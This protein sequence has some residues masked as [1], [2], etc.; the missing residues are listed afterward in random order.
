MSLFEKREDGA[1]TAAYLERHGETI[2]DL[3]TEFVDELMQKRPE[4]VRSYLDDRL[5]KNVDGQ[6]RNDDNATNAQLRE[7]NDRLRKELEVIRAQARLASAPV[8]R[9]SRPT[10]AKLV[11]PQ[12]SETRP[13]SQA[14]AP[15]SA[16]PDGNT[17]NSATTILYAPG[18]DE[19][20]DELRKHLRK[21]L[22]NLGSE[23]GPCT[24]GRRSRQHPILLTADLDPCVIVKRSRT[25][26]PPK[27]VLHR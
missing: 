3:L 4:N 8:K 5:H 18:M 15:S 27:P 7:E 13:A 16:E 23:L 20:A 21:D 26:H 6:D 24:V 12:A 14:M 22:H 9:I 25:Q 1:A 17:R 19:M 11:R 10:G 2:E